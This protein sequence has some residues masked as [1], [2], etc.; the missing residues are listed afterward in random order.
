MGSSRQD[1]AAIWQRHG[2]FFAFLYASFAISP[3]GLNDQF[4]LRQEQ[5]PQLVAGSLIALGVL[6]VAFASTVYLRERPWVQMWILLFVP[7]LA[8][9]GR[10][11]SPATSPSCLPVREW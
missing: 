11:P 7:V 4:G 10:G 6:I 8:M 3:Q 9:V 1:N 2:I 5:D